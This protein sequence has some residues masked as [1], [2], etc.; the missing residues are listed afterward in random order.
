[1]RDGKQADLS[2]EALEWLQMMAAKLELTGRF[3][4]DGETV[5]EWKTARV[6]DREKV[7]S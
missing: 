2:V 5:I 4:W 7:N 3:N 1:M 6:H